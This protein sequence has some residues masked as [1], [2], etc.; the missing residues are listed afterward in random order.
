MGIQ[1]SLLN[2]I[3]PEVRK[4]HPYKVGVP[5]GHINVKLNQN[6]SPFD[7]PSELR[8]AVISAWREIA[9][10]RYPTEQPAD[11]AKIIADYIGWD[12]RGIILGNGSNELTYTLGLALINPNSR[13]VLPR[14]MFSFYERVVNIYGGEIMSIAPRKNLQ[15]DIDAVLDAVTRTEPSI[16]VIT[17]PNNPTS[18]VVPQEE[19]KSIAEATSGLVLIDE[20]YIEFAEEPSLLS[21][22]NQFPNVILLRTFSKAFG[23][24]GLRLGYLIGDPNLMSE[25]M[26]VRPPF[27]IDRFSI[28]VVKELLKHTDLIHSRTKWIRSETRR[29]TQALKQLKGVHVL[30]GQANFVT[31]QVSCDSQALFRA[32]AGSGVLVRDMSG[33]SELKGFLRV[34]TGT[35]DENREF[36]RALTVAIP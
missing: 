27:M 32:L 17:T 21:V 12:E 35:S 2:Q 13:V 18:L 26:K 15:F 31:F 33:Y 24:A 11:L 8:E 28:C 5:P 25:I 22:L 34:T 16:V 23:L 4:Q 19:I 29:L 30:E 1:N 36:L 9:F 20:A 7:L 6:E 14:P 3:K 10:N